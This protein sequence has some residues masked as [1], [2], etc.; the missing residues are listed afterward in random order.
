MTL[1]NEAIEKLGPKG[2]YL[3]HITK[4]SA[5]TTPTCGCTVEVSDKKCDLGEALFR[6][7]EKEKRRPAREEG[8]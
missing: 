5:S 8:R 1:K 6:L 2:W 3:D 7:R 4:A